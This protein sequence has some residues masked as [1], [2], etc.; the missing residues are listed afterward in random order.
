MGTDLSDAHGRGSGGLSLPLWMK[1][2]SWTGAEPS[3]TG[4]L[5]RLKRGQQVGLTRRGKGSKL[6]L[7]VENHG[8]PMG[9]LVASAPQA[10]VKL[11]EPTLAT[12]KVPRLCGR[13]RTRPKEVVTDKGYDS[14]LLRGRLRKRGIK[15]C[16]PERRG[17]RPRPGPKA[18]LAGY[19]HRWKVERTYAWLG[20]YRRLVVRYEWLSYVYLAFVMMAFIMIC[21]AALLK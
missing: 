20:N 6:R 4:A 3:W 19:S 11:A 2:G 9:G 1:Q 12:V 14:R 18:D 13:P 15:P 16:I 17:Q 21:L 7:V 8:L 5:Y 10:E